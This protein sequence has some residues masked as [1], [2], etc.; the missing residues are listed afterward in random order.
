MK[1]LIGKQKLLHRCVS[2]RFIYE[3]IFC[4]KHVE[5]GKFQS[6]AKCEVAF[7]PHQGKNVAVDPQTE[8]LRSSRDGRHHHYRV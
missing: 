1:H 5:R 7:A 8:P 2:V 4:C 3:E 6:D